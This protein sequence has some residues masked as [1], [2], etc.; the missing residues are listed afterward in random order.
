MKSETISRIRAE[1]A[2]REAMMDHD[3]AAEVTTELQG[4]IANSAHD[5][6]SP[7]TAL[8]LRIESVYQSL[9]L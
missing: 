5:V 8:T 7:C 9:L 2:V 4:T 6:K 3:I 1:N